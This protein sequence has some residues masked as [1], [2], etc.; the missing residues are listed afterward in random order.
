MAGKQPSGSLNQTTLEHE[1]V[2]LGHGGLENLF[3]ELNQRYNW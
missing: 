1:G 3:K 2:L